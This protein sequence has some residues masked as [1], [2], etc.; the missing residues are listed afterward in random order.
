MQK[1]VLV[2]DNNP[3]ALKLME[4]LL[5]SHVHDLRL[6]ED[7]L[8]AIEILK[9]FTPDVIFV[10]L[11]MPMVDGR[12]VCRVVRRQ[13]RFDHTVITILSAAAAEGEIELDE[14]GADYCIAKGPFK[15][16]AVHV[17]NMLTAER[18]YGF[19]PAPPIIGLEDIFHREITAELLSS[20]R[21]LELI[22]RNTSEG[23]VEFSSERGIIFANRKVE[24]L[25][26]KV[27]EEVLALDFLVLFDEGGIREKVAAA[28]REAVRS[29]QVFRMEETIIMGGKHVLLTLLPVLE[30]EQK[31]FIAQ[32]QDVTAQKN[33]EEVEGLLERQAKLAHADRLS[34]LGEMV[35]GITHELR[36]PLTVI[37]MT[38][39]V[40]RRLPI[41]D[42]TLEDGVGK[43]SDQVNRATAIIDSMSYFSRVK[44]GRVGLIAPAHAVERGLAFFREQFRVHNIT[45]EVDLDQTAFFYGR[46][47]SIEQIVV[48]LLTNAR[49]AV[50]QRAQEEKNHIK[51][52]M[53]TLAADQKKKVI[54][55]TVADNGIGF[56][57]KEKQKCFEPFFT[58]KPE[59]EGTGLGLTIIKRLADEMQGSVDIADPPGGEGCAV[60]LVFPMEKEVVSH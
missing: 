15:K 59:G 11:I 8:Q 42:P 1:K 4:N 49:H 29:G 39:Q 23:I 54:R 25:T 34:A 17:L 13:A 19:S 12:Q 16:Q 3:V 6:A 40:I 20:K 56:N 53:V 35:S 5:A 2:V 52:V 37:S 31:C 26:G 18:R 55:L 14:V 30:G 28:V 60:T 9:T 43:I 46:E 22:L 58:T 47:Q 51:K 50:E 33:L 44:S 36:Q 57:E 10:D 21:H 24:M 32:L 41:D 27:E 45:L 38:S 48:N 7:G